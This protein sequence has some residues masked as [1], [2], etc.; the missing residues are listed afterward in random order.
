MSLGETLPTQN[1]VPLFDS[2]Q[3]NS[4]TDWSCLISGSRFGLMQA[5]VALATVLS[6][7]DVSVCKKTPIPI[8]FDPKIFV[9]SSKE[10]IFLE[11]SK[12]S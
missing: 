2:P 8:V 12:R 1:Y 7:F 4:L 3:L 5:K 11:I 6:K 9:M 10:E